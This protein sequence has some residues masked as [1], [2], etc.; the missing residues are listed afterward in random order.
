MEQ[1]IGF[2]G[3]VLSDLSQAPRVNQIIGQYQELVE[4]RIGIPDHDSKAA[5]IGL[6]VRG[7]DAALSQLTAK[8]GNVPGASVKSAMTAK[9]MKGEETI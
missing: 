4:G 1:R 6:I 7:G 3:I 2:V 8:L 5:V 9:R